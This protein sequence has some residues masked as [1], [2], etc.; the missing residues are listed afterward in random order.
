MIIDVLFDRLGYSQ[1]ISFIIFAD[2]F[3]LVGV[4]ESHFSSQ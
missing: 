1:P 3:G 2:L 4:N